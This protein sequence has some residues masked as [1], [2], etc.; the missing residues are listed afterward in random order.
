MQGCTCC[1]GLPQSHVTPL[2]PCSLS[3]TQHH[4]GSWYCKVAPDLCCYNIR[5]STYP[6]STTLYYSQCA[7]EVTSC[8]ETPV[9]PGFLCNTPY[10]HS[11]SAMWPCVVATSARAPASLSTI[12]NYSQW[13]LHRS[14]AV[15]NCWCCSKGRLMHGMYTRTPVP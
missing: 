13:A 9:V 5:F 14:P 10:L 2:F 15:T 8:F 3:D 6:L 1:V 7:R 11:G 12:L 4:T